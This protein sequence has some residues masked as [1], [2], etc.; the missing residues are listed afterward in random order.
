MA[1]LSNGDKHVQHAAEPAVLG[2]ADEA[3]LQSRTLIDDSDFVTAREDQ[4]LRRGLHQRHIGLIAIAGAIV[5]TLIPPVPQSQLVT[6][7]KHSCTLGHG[8]LPWS[9]RVYSEGWAAGRSPGI[10]NR[11]TDRLRGPIRTG[12]SDGLASCH[13]KLCATCRS[14][15][16]PSARVCRWVR[17]MSY[18]PMSISKRLDKISNLRNCN[19]TGTT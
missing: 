15:H 13:W 11:R 12:R 10:R 14:P 7:H 17:P 19:K 9:R 4:D 6:A 16:R 1:S 5:R 3:Q 18:C 8:S 2:E